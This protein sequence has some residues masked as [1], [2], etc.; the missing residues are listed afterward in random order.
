MDRDSCVPKGAPR[1][2]A[3]LFEVLEPRPL[4]GGEQTNVF[5][6]GFGAAG[7]ETNSLLKRP[8]SVPNRASTLH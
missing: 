5:A 8:S 2:Q 6:L 1:P 3:G 4:G 7:E